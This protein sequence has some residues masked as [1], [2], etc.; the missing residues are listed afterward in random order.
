[1]ELE[2][3]EPSFGALLMQK[4]VQARE[5]WQSWQHLPG[6]EDLAV[7]ASIMEQLTPAALEQLGAHARLQRLQLSMSGLQVRE[8]YASALRRLG[9][10]E[11]SLQLSLRHPED[12]ARVLD[13]LKSVLLHTLELSLWCKLTST[14]A[15]LLA[16]CSFTR[17]VLRS[18]DPG[19]RLEQQLPGVVVEYIPL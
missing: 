11:L 15:G 14:H 12:I 3:P 16:Q 13:C 1:M 4:Q 17:L 18:D 9:T 6:L 5:V 7:T 8:A 2:C 10:V 19:W